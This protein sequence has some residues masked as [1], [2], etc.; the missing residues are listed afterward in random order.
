MFCHLKIV[1]QEFAYLFSRLDLKILELWKISLG[2]FDLFGKRN[3]I[4]QFL[5]GIGLKKCKDFERWLFSSSFLPIFSFWISVTDVELKRLK[6][7]FKRT[8][9]LSYYMGQHC[10]IRE[11]LGDGV[12]PKVAE[13]IFMF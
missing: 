4:C 2:L 1:G 10:F 8:C 11:V 9:G 7:A 13:V 3:N 6:D 5:L 12:P